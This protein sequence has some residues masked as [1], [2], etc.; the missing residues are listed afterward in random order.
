[1]LDSQKLVGSGLV[2]RVANPPSCTVAAP[3]VVIKSYDCL[4]LFI[5]LDHILKLPI[6]NKLLHN[7]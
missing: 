5:Y 3:L 6:M 1:M 4:I 2:R 7:L